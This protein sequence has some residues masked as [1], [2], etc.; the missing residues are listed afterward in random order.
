[1]VTSFMALLLWF[2]PLTHIVSSLRYYW[3]ILYA[4]LLFLCHKSVYRYDRYLPAR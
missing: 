4:C 3:S 1:M 2:F